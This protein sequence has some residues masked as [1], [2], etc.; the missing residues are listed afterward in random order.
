M[1]EPRQFQLGE[2]IDATLAREQRVAEWVASRETDCCGIGDKPRCGRC[3]ELSTTNGYVMS[4]DHDLGYMGCPAPSGRFG[5]RKMLSPHELQQRHDNVHHAPCKCR[6]AWGVHSV[7]W[8]LPEEA[9]CMLCGC[10]G[11]RERSTK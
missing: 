11:Y 5:D 6:H 4:L 9:S 3:G 8:Y 10:Q 2:D 1:G 7:Q